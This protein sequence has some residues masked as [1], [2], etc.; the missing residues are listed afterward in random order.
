MATDPNAVLLH[1]AGKVHGEWEQYEIDSDLL[2]A[3]D[4]WQVSLGV[5]GR[6]IPAALVPG[7]GITVSIGNDLVLT[8][9]VGKTVHRIAKGSNTL[10]LS[11]RDG[12]AN[13][14]DC[15][16]PLVTARQVSLEE[17]MASVVR[18]LGITKIRIDADSTLLREKIHVD[19]GNTAWE[20]LRNAAEANGYWPW[21]EPD[22]TLVIGGPDYST[23]PVASLVLRVNGKGNNVEAMDRELSIEDRFSEVTVL[24]QSHGTEIALGENALKSTVKDSSMSIYRPKIVVDSEADNIEIARKRGRKL[25]ADG[26]LSGETVTVTVKGH[27]TDAGSLW[28]PGQRVN[29]LSEPHGVNAVYFLMGRKFICSR[30]DG[31]KTIL[32]LKEDGAWVLDAHPHSKHHQRAIVPTKDGKSKTLEIIE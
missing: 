32:T 7:V 28:K 19:P 30:M 11:G 23:P 1:L 21:F 25:L 22:G 2:I 20:V 10:T 9:M 27:R 6:N 12:A 31:R 14:L 15:S 24:S 16:S 4:G 5:D 29:V 13:L 26:H 17:I 8:G 18:P 3:A